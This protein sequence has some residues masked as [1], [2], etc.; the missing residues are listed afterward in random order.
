LK[1]EI[2]KWNIAYNNLEHIA[3]DGL[4]PNEVLLNN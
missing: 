1:R 2:K 3:L 4:T